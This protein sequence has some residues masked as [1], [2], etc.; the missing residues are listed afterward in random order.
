MEDKMNLTKKEIDIVIYL[1]DF[2]VQ[3]INDV[4]YSIQKQSN[5]TL[6]KS[7]DVDV[8]KYYLEYIYEDID[9]YIETNQDEFDDCSEAQTL[10][11]KIAIVIKNKVGVENENKKK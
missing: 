5:Q 4:S 3:N 11:D 10:K 1:L 8:P 6:E 2:Y 9:T 7:I